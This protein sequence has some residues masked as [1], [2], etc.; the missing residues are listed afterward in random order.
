MAFSVVTFGLVALLL[1]GGFIEW[2]YSAGRESAIESQLGHIQITRPGYF[3]RGFAEPF[4]FL[5]PEHTPVMDR[6][7]RLPE[8]KMITPRLAFSG[9]ISHKDHTISFLGEGVVPKTEAQVSRWLAMMRGAQLASADDKGVILGAGLAA[10]LGAG[11]GDRVVLM[12]TKLNGGFGA[13][14]VTVRGVFRT[15]SKS[16]DDYALRVPLAVAQRLLNVSGVHTWVVLLKNTAQ[17]DAVLHYLQAKFPRDSSG[18]F[19]FTP[20]YK[21]SDFYNK[22]VA[23]FSRQMNVLRAMIAIIVVLSISNSMIANVF[24]RTGEIGTLLA[25][26][27]RRRRIVGLFMGEGLLLGVLGGILGVV[28]GWLAAQ[29]IS[30]VG[31]PMPPSPGMAFG[32]D[33]KI[34]LTPMLVVGG[35][36]LIVV[37]TVAA[38][39]YPA[40]RASRLVIVDALRYNR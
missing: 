14:E 23:L 8:V 1:A 26:G 5:M 40:W 38:S 28:V 35:F 36:L 19:E 29:I 31:I 27:Y 32:F 39:L 22:T 34:L 13:V 18:P 10:N 2:I 21:L 3:E 11:V 25:L 9:L 17:T 20:W 7:A 37:T 30:A 24:E 15:P 6:V 4:A 12:V 33:A 16:Y